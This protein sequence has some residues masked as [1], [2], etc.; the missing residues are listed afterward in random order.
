MNSNWL[1]YRVRKLNISLVFIAQPFFAV[2]KNIRLNSM[3]YFIVK[4]PNKREFQQIA[5]N[6]SS[7]IDFKD[8]MTLYKKCTKKSYSFLVINAVLPSDNPLHF[9]KWSCRNNKN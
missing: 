4:I 2:P 3:Q 8:F 1:T 7:D 9:K 6:H 5:F